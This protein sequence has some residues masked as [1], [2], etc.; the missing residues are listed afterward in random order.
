MSP[1]R[2]R[3]G[4][5]WISVGLVFLAN[6]LGWLS[7]W[8]W[9]DL[10]RLWPVLLIVIGLEMIVR[11][12]KLEW[13]GYLSTLILI[14][15][16]AWAVVQAKGYYYDDDLRLLRTGDSEV[17]CDYESGTSAKINVRFADGRLRFSNG[18]DYLFR[19]RARNSRDDVSLSSDCDDNHCDIYL[20]PTEL[21]LRGLLRIRDD[22]N[23]WSCYVHRG[24]SASYQLELDDADLRFD[25]DDFLIDTLKVD[26]DR[27]SLRIRLGDDRRLVYLDLEGNG[28]DIELLLPQTAGIRIEGETIRSASRDRF[29]LQEKDG[30]LV[31]ALYQRAGANFHI[32]ANMRNGRLRLRGY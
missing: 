7:W 22:D 10:L 29:D 24:V 11:K 4:I 14:G 17:R 2:V 31:N 6:N 18:S 20:R 13:L 25:G 19:A 15:A 16:F 28:T 3:W 5:F 8:V 12:S 1:S 30:E 27:S 23:Y 32:K 26:A 9:A 21:R